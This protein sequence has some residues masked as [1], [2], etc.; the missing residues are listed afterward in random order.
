MP[1][2]DALK[3]GSR[4]CDT[5]AYLHER[6]VIHR[7]LKPQNI[8]MCYDG[9][10]RLMDFGIAAAARA[11]ASPT[12]ASRPHGHARLHGARTGQGQTW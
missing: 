4:I 10:I 1:I 5:L 7:D 2:S 8:M 6:S 9:T 12:R 11:D 3:L